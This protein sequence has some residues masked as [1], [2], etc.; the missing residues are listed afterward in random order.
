MV[1]QTIE[2]FRHPLR[3]PGYVFLD[4]LG[5][6]S[7]GAGAAAKLA[8]AS[9]IAKVAEAGKALQGGTYRFRTPL[10]AAPKTRASAGFRQAEHMAGRIGAPA[11]EANYVQ[12]LAHGSEL[13]KAQHAALERTGMAAAPVEAILSRSPAINLAQRAAL[14]FHEAH[15]EMRMPIRGVRMGDL[16]T[17]LK[18]EQD[19]INRVANSVQAQYS[20]LRKDAASAGYLDPNGDLRGVLDAEGQLREPSAAAKGVLGQSADFINSLAKIA[21]LYTKPGYAPPNMLGQILLSTQQHSFN[22]ISI[23]RSVRIQRHLYGD[24]GLLAGERS[25]KI[26]GAMQEQSGFVTAG[27]GPEER[28]QIRGRGAIR[29]TQALVHSTE[30]VLANAYSKVIDTPFRD[31]AFFAEAVKAGIKTPEAVAKLVDEGGPKFMEIAR[32]ANREMIDYARLGPNERRFW[33]RAIFFYPWVKGATI[34]GGH[35]LLEHPVQST[36]QLKAGV[37]QGQRTA[38]ELGPLPSYLQGAFKVGGTKIPGLGQS[39]TIINPVAATLLGQTA[40]VWLTGLGTLQGGSARKFTLTQQLSPA[41]GIPLS[42]ATGVNYFTGQHYRNKSIPDILYSQ[43]KETF[44]PTKRA[45][46]LISKR[47]KV[48]TG[49]LLA[50]DVLEPGTSDQP[51]PGLRSLPTG[52]SG[53]SWA[54]EPMLQFLTGLAPR[55]LNPAR[56]REETV[57]EKR[58]GFNKVQAEAARH[59]DYKNRYRL[60]AE[61]KGLIPKGGQLPKE[62]QRA[63]ALR[64]QLM[65]AQKQYEMDSGGGTVPAARRLGITLGLLVKMGGMSGAERASILKSVLDSGMGDSQVRALERKFRDAYFG[66]AVLSQYKKVLNA[67][68]A[69]I[70]VP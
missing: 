52:V 51:I 57:K 15:P 63:F 53:Q 43:A 47:E 66:G 37:E 38:Q 23:A 11:E 45:Q 32:R 54:S 3:H 7:L 27:G 22:P 40:D 55:A 44:I 13:D 19:E 50:K 9:R 29:G 46:Q 31:N 59:A 64:S 48:R 67:Y 16:Q 70:T 12:Q 42:A 18:F 10:A 8:A 24:E 65:Q 60:T 30:D 26:K 69:N 1:K 2:D 33:R 36:A 5:M 39:P 41:I 56:A 58:E 68:G 17:R 6:V 34:Y 61:E 20:K 14:R 49:K 25:A 62:V 4:T 21:L 28:F 35:Y